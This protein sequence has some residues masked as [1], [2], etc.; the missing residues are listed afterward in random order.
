MNLVNDYK[1][2]K[3][4]ISSE[5]PVSF[6]YGEEYINVWQLAWMFF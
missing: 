5:Y 4:R 2:Q 6:W 1:I 3:Q